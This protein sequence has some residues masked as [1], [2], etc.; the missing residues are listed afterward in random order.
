[1]P[2]W[3]TD[4]GTNLF[5]K[6][7]CKRCTHWIETDNKGVMLPHKCLDLKKPAKKK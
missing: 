5:G 2:S 7:Q 1:M 4:E 6:K 3:T